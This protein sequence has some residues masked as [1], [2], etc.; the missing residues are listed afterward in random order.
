MI[1]SWDNGKNI[2]RG[3]KERKRKAYPTRREILIKNTRELK[4]YLNLYLR[5]ER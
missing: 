5:N 4:K 3:E 2:R 1:F